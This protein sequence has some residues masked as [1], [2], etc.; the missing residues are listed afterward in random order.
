M[1]MLRKLED[2]YNNLQE[3]YRLLMCMA[4]IMCWNLPITFGLQYGMP[5][6]VAVGF[7]WLVMMLAWG[8]WRHL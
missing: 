6:L 2:W 8:I 7:I 1:N 3:P 4:M 5:I